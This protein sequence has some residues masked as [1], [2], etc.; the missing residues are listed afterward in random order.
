[1]LVCVRCVA[2]QRACAAGCSVLLRA[3][4]QLLLRPSLM[5]GAHP[6]PSC[7]P[8]ACT[9]PLPPAHA[10]FPAAP[11][12]HPSR[13]ARR[14][15]SRQPS[16]R[17][18]GSRRRR[19]WRARSPCTTRTRAA[20]SPHSRSTVSGGRQQGP[21]LR[22]VLA[23]C[24]SWVVGCCTRGQTACPNARPSAHTTAPPCL[25]NPTCTPH[26]QHQELPASD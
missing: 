7:L 26:I 14:R 1:M 24:C 15:R 3:R 19:T 21:V 6:S 25:P 4:V 22:G 23:F 13:R 20:R 11:S 18:P 5:G 2:W 8:A 10:M 16:Q 9:Y 12:Q 17:H